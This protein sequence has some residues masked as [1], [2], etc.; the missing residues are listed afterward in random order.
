MGEAKGVNVSTTG[1]KPLRREKVDVVKADRPRRLL[2]FLTQLRLRKRKRGRGETDTGRTLRRGM[3]HFDPNKKHHDHFGSRKEQL[4]C[5]GASFLLPR[6]GKEI[7][8]LEK[9]GKRKQK[10]EEVPSAF[11]HCSQDRL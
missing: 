3:L 6:V 10:G 1:A 9:R 2:F 8:R 7:S 5:G 4:F 11:R